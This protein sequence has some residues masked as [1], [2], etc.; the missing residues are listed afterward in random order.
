M[1]KLW[2]AAAAL[3]ACVALVL[4]LTHLDHAAPVEPVQTD[5]VV[6]PIICTGGD[7]SW[8]ACI[9]TVA[10]AYMSEHPNV[11]VEVNATPNYKGTTYAEQLLVQEALGKFN[12]IVELSNPELYARAGKLSPLPESLTDQMKQAQ[13]TDGAVYAIPRYYSCRGILYNKSVFQRLG[14]RPPQSYGDFLSLC[15]ALKAAGITPLA[16]GAEDL[17]HMAQW[18]NALFS[19]NVK[20]VQ[21]DWIRL[22]DQGQVHWSDPEPLSML[23]DLKTLFDSGYVKSDFATTSNTGTIG[24]LAGGQ[25]A[26]LCSGT[27]M[28]SQIL[29]NSP[30][31]DLGWFFLPNDAGTA[32]LI[33][34]NTDWQWAITAACR[35][36]EARYEAA[37]DLLS[38][39]YS[40]ET[41]RTVLQTM[42]GF[43]SLKEDL[44]YTTVPVQANI[45]RQVAEAGVIEGDTLSGGAVPEGVSNQLYVE[46]V[47]LAQGQ[48]TVAETAARLDEIWDGALEKTK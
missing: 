40:E 45:A 26:M 39:F 21:P 3:L 44:S 8:T 7:A 17:W 15:E 23:S 27:W 16:V 46:L 10:N 19:K 25:A 18:A 29:K 6:L 12:G 2:F 42:N 4:G 22:R 14:L 31:L 37:V 9:R 20:S 30:D 5:S 33:Q 47:A 28:I 41:Y 38:F 36:D 11:K 13:N 35:E 34:L 32:P 48:R 24:I 1:K 43:S